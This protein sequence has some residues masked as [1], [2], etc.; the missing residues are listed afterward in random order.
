MST[1]ALLLCSAMLG[2]CAFSSGLRYETSHPETAVVMGGAVALPI[3]VRT[4]YAVFLENQ[5]PSWQTDVPYVEFMTWGRWKQT[6]RLELSVGGDIKLASPSSVA[7]GGGLKGLLTPT[8]TSQRVHF[9]ISVSPSVRLY[10]WD[11]AFVTWSTLVAFPLTFG[12]QGRPQF[13]VRPEARMEGM[14]ETSE[15]FI[16]TGSA[17]GGRF[18][19]TPGRGFARRYADCFVEA[20]V[21]GWVATSENAPH[22]TG[23]VTVIL[24]IGAIF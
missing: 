20:S 23:P 4:D 22:R 24:G 14:F 2:S 6:D 3:R 16:E 10:F 15:W 18:A 5:T 13:Y 12:R 8:D 11:D 21:T 7:I 9:A 19:C 1:R 17:V